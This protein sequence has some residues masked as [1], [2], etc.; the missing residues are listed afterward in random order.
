METLKSWMGE[1]GLGGQ[2]EPVAALA[3]TAGLLLL[4]VVAYYITKTIVLRVVKSAAKRSKT[5]WDDA[6]EI[7]AAHTGRSIP[8]NCGPSGN[9]VS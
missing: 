9:S 2:A 8:L 1:L 3:A 6:L 7:I 5:H 4:A